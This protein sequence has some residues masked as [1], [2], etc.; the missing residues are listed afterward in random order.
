M[1]TIMES[2]LE[3]RK[4]HTDSK[5]NGSL[6]DFQ[7]ALDSYTLGEDHIWDDLVDT[8]T[9]QLFSNLT[10]MLQRRDKGV[11]LV[12]KDKVK[13]GGTLQRYSNI[14]EKLMAFQEDAKQSVPYIMQ[15]YLMGKEEERFLSLGVN[16]DPYDVE[17]F[18]E[19]EEDYMKGVRNLFKEEIESLKKFATKRETMDELKVYIRLYPTS[20]NIL[21]PI[22]Q[23]KASIL[24]N[25]EVLLTASK[26]NN[27]TVSLNRN[28]ALNTLDTQ[29]LDLY[30]TFFD[31]WIDSGNRKFQIIVGDYTLNNCY[32]Q[33][34]PIF[35]Q[36]MEA[37]GFFNL[38]FVSS[39]ADARDIK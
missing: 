10:P 24:S 11:F 28:I 7:K 25:N 37:A 5:M 27:L 34:S 20:A 14:Y 19:D 16:P 30:Q 29:W 1:N 18:L 12:F 21:L 9:S 39:I 33:E 6:K 32:L 22:R 23:T 4:L 35:S 38:N 8:S 17:L 36:S 2:P 26:K 15:T 3:P 13:K 31:Y